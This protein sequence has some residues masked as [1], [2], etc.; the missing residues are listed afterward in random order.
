MVHWRRQWQTT[1]VFLDFPGG[2]TGKESACNAGDLGSIPGLLRSP[3]GGHGNPLQDSC[4]ENPMDRGAWQA[5]VHRVTKSWVQLKQLSMH[6]HKKPKWK[7]TNLYFHLSPHH[8][9]GST[10]TPIT[11]QSQFYLLGFSAPSHM[12]FSFDFHLYC[13]AVICV[14]RLASCL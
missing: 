11:Q 1:P 6:T 4:L 2:S 5:Q 12:W 10:F 14:I 8:L 3:G 9:S 7:Q 13:Q